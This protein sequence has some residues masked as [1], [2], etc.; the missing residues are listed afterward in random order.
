MRF[1][2]ATGLA[3]FVLGLICDA[4]LLA[5][6]LRT[7]SFSPYKIVGFTGVA[8]NAGGLLVAGL[9]L[10]ADM[11]DRMRINQ[12]RLLYFHKKH[13]FEHP[14]GGQISPGPEST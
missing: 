5:Y 8:L 14:D 4:W 1:F 9:G 11:L 2:G 7:G 10:L 6:W 12:E 3:L 13:T